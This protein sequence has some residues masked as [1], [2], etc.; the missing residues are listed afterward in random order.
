MDLRSLAFQY[1]HPAGSLAVACAN[2]R[3]H[4]TWRIASRT[5][6]SASATL[7]SNAMAR[8]PDS[9]KIDLAEVFRRVQT[10]MLAHLS[11]FNLIEHAIT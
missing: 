4:N 6:N 11:V 10:E 5:A 9:G 2:L 8:K 3:R 7:A 1:S